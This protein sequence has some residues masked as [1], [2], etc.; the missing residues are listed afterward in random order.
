MNKKLKQELNAFNE[1]LLHRTS[2][3]T[4]ELYTSSLGVYF[5]WLSDRKPS[6]TNAQ[7]FLDEAIVSGKSAST[8]GGYGRAITKWF[9]WKGIEVVLDVPPVEMKDPHYLTAKQIDELL[10]GCSG[11]E[12]LIIAILFDTAIRINEFMNIR[13]CDVDFDKKVIHVT[14]K[15][16]HRDT[17]NIDERLLDLLK[18][19]MRDK[20][21]DDNI[22]AGLDY[23]KAL[24]L[25]KDAGKRIGVDITPHTLRH[26]R[27]IQMLNE[28]AELW[29]V[30][31][32]LGHTSIAT[33]AN[34]YGRFTK[35]H[36]KDKIPAW[37]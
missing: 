16:G 33:T 29:V 9:K 13:V 4:A 24:K 17:V 21:P 36:L 18:L 3:G 34:V 12:Y 15:G 5:E 1:Y 31:Q 6:A 20:S 25:V 23:N 28:G 35:E 26:S 14:R 2:K 11:I 19:Y 30:Q 10:A 22:F 32:H 7:Q 37:C 8:V 27:A